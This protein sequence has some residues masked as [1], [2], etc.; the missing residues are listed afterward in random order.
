MGQGLP[1]WVAVRPEKEPPPELKGQLEGLAAVNVGEPEF[2]D[3]KPPW[4]YAY[5]EL[6]SPGLGM[7]E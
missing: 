4:L 2:F 7:S 3:L 1:A 6:A 5:A